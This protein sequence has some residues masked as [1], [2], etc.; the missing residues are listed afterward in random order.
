MS[1]IYLSS[2]NDEQIQIIE[3]IGLNN[4]IR[5]CEYAGGESIYF[6]SMRSAKILARNVNI[7]KEFNGKNYKYLSNKYCICERHI[8]RIVNSKD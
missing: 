8:R 2:L 1:E 7:R 4:F 6:P 5:L 3:L